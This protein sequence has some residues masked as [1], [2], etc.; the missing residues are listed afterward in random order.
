MRFLADK[1]GVCI[2]SFDLPADLLMDCAVAVGIVLALKYPSNHMP[3][4]VVNDSDNFF[5]NSI[6]IVHTTD[7]RG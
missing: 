7:K 1:I 5:G 3:V 6:D 4:A 2:S